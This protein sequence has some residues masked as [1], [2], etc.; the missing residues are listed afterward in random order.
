MT[1]AGQFDIEEEPRRNEVEFRLHMVSFE[2]TILCVL[3]FA[4][5]F[6]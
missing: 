3:Q 5:L 2:N 6:T 4:I 1:Q